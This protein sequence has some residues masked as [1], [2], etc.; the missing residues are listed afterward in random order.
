MFFWYYYL[1]AKTKIHTLGFKYSSY[2]KTHQVL[3]LNLVTQK[4]YNS[5][6]NTLNWICLCKMFFTFENV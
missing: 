5:K 3:Q 1:K 2:L 6:V 4:I